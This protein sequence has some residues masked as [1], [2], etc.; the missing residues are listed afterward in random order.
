MVGATVSTN[1]IRVAVGPV[2][3]LEEV[4]FALVRLL[5]VEAVAEIQVDAIA[6][7]G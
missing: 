3:D 5:D 2:V 6:I 1:Q 7:W 4:V